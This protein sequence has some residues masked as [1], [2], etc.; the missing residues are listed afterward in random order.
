MLLYDADSAVIPALPCHADFVAVLLRLLLYGADSTAIL[1]CVL[2]Y[3]ADSAA[4]PALP[5][6]ADSVAFLL[7]VLLHVLCIGSVDGWWH[8]RTVLSP[9]QESKATLF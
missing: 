5:S 1:L 2:R 3:A 7:R 4:I 8:S 9:L 6:E